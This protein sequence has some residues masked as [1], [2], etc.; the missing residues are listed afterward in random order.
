[1]NDCRT[2]KYNTYYGVTNEWLSC[3]HPITLAKQPQWVEGDP[4]FV[5]YRTGDVNAEHADEFRDCPT[6]EKHP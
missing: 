5:S 1:M 6:W 4:A 3:S 2:C